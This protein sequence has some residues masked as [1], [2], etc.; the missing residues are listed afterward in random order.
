MT[1]ILLFS[2]TKQPFPHSAVVVLQF[3]GIYDPFLYNSHLWPWSLRYRKAQGKSKGN[4]N[5]Y[6][7]S[8]LVVGAF[9][10]MISF[11]FFGNIT[12]LMLYIFV[13]Y[14]VYFYKHWSWNLKSDLFSLLN[15]G[16]E[17]G[18]EFRLQIPCS[19]HSNTHKHTHKHTHTQTHTHTHLLSIGL[20][21]TSAV[22]AER[23]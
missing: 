22:Q 15:K 10:W 17:P 6:C 23:M 11:K 19:F 3:L 5:R 21:I 20:W 16:S 12:S 7:I 18:Q 8:G 2:S 4:L 14:I 9:A 1:Q 13:M